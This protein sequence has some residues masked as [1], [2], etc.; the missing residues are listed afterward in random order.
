MDLREVK[1][2]A[3]YLFTFDEL[4]FHFIALHIIIFNELHFRLTTV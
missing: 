1:V 2:T 4:R 3:T